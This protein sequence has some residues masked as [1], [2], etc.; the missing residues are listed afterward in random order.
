M[1]INYTALSK[2]S[3]LNDLKTIGFEI[4]GALTAGKFFV[5]LGLGKGW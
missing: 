4:L 1:F 5:S 3:H 2:Y